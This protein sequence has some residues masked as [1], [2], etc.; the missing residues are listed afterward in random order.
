L[1]PLKNPDTEFAHTESAFFKFPL[2]ARKKREFKAICCV[3]SRWLLAELGIKHRKGDATMTAEQT[4]EGAG[5]NFCG[6]QRS[7]KGE[8]KAA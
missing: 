7:F 6:N 8:G 4:A 3:P 1:L 2:K 5:E